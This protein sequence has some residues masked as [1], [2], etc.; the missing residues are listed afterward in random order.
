MDSRLIRDGFANGELIIENGEL[1]IE[2]A[3]RGSRGN[4]TLPG[5]TD[6]NAARREIYRDAKRRL[7]HGVPV[8]VLIRDALLKLRLVRAGRKEV[9]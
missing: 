3:I 1:G 2:G 5:G 9:R 8:D 4:A 7:E 6:L